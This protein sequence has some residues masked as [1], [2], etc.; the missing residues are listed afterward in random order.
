M[1][2]FS[3]F[4]PAVR[5]L[6][7]YDAMVVPLILQFQSALAEL[8]DE[9][10]KTY[11]AELRK[12]AADGATEKELL[13]EAFAL[14][15]EV[16]RRVIGLEH[17]KEQL[18][19]GIALYYGNVAEMKTG[20]GKTLVATCPLYL[21]A[22]MGHRGHLVTVNDYLAK[23]DREWMGPVYKF[24]DVSVGLLQNDSSPEERRAA[25]AADIT[26]GTNNE[27][28]FDYLRDHL[29]GSEDDK[30]QKGSL[31]FAIVDEVDNI[32]ID[33]A[34]TALIIAGPGP[35]RDL[36]YFEAVAFVKRLKGTPS[37]EVPVGET[38]V[39]VGSDYVYDEKL[40]TINP[41]DDLLARFAH[42]ARIPEGEMMEDQA[43][44]D[45]V[46]RNAIKA[47]IFFKK[48]RQYIVQQGQV[49][50]VDEFTGRLMNGRRYS[51]GLH[52][53]IEAKE[54][55]K[56]NEES[57]TV[58]TITFQKFFK[59]YHKLS[60]MTG[61]AL[62]E[63]EEF[64]EIYN[65]DVLEIP[66]HRPMVR[67][68]EDDEVYR[69][70]RGK[71]NAILHEIQDRHED[72][73]PILIG[74]RSV[75]K[76]EMLSHELKK[77]DIKHQMLNAK[78]AN[79][80]KE[81]E[82]IAQAGRKGT[83]TI[84]TNMA[85]RGVDILLGGNPKALAHAGAVARTKADPKKE[86]E[87]YAQQYAD[88]YA[89][90]LA[91]YSD[92]WAKEHNEVVRLGG[93]FILG[94]ER[95]ESRRIDNQLRGR[96]GRQ[97][98]PGG[99][100]FFLSAEDD[101]LRIFGGER[102]Q[103]IFSVMK[104][105][106]STP[107]NHPLLSKTIEMSQKRIES[108]SF[109]ARKD[110]VQYDEVLDVKRKMIYDERDKVLA[111][112]DL[113]E[114]VHGFINELAE[115]IGQGVIVQMRGGEESDLGRAYNE[116]CLEAFDRP[117][118]MTLQELTELVERRDAERALGAA[119][120]E[121]AEAVYREKYNRYGENVMHQIE[122]FFFLRSID[123]AWKE[124]LLEMEDLKDGINLRGYAGTPPLVQYQKEGSELFDDAMDQIE[125]DVTRALFTFELQPTQPEKKHDRS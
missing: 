52:E 102:I 100:K 93:L 125:H 59:L 106:E 95:N 26:Y 87:E 103:Q 48:D 64:Q 114:Q 63:E 19:G 105:D 109:D 47:Q 3:S 108:M 101:V 39:P 33:E 104:V 60:G 22:V 110:L 2:L 113:S 5:K 88:E 68:D 20:E 11:G 98:D 76:S 18:V 96:A 25:Y 77:L 42:A 35:K 119:I 23:R 83:V 71:L 7:A 120:G 84:A 41:A 67:K 37:S 10:L 123:N 21:N 38:G 1:G 72:G 6:K 4:S 80:K 40:R 54:G 14:V 58:A 112:G 75:Q 15:R 51:E 99:S 82:I 97:G 55:L 62:T 56:V 81:A 94:T 13:P 116:Q 27:F 9:G 28:G 49:V 46:L 122:H 17:F 85:G 117:I 91:E 118:A 57:Q 32:F 45:I 115:K 111:G 16:S 61:T 65:L 8:D 78:P 31:D 90:L 66:T 24:L 30:V 73:Q 50:I 12:R 34:R 86:P 29:V 69:S 92:A 43:R 70:E 89:K 53:A 79:Q 124:Y 107:V 44:Y 121:R 36:R 74:T